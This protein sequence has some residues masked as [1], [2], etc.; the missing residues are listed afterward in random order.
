MTGLSKPKA[1]YPKPDGSRIKYPSFS[2]FAVYQSNRS[3][4]A[5]NIDPLANLPHDPHLNPNYASD[6]ENQG[7]LSFLDVGFACICDGLDPTN[8]SQGFTR[9]T[10]GTGGVP[11]KL[12][13]VDRLWQFSNN[14]DQ[15]TT[16]NV[17]N[18]YDGSC[19]L[20]NGTEKQS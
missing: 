1:T 7:A 10:V 16:I 12:W 2:S 9:C 6:Y 18:T 19:F 4:V 20:S 17:T 8:S 3:L 11:Q 15:N 5:V 13:I 14:R